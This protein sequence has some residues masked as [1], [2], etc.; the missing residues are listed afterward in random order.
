MNFEWS[1]AVQ[2]SYL[3]LFSYYMLCIC[4]RYENQISQVPT[5]L[6]LESGTSNTPVPS[7]SNEIRMS[8]SFL[9]EVDDQRFCHKVEAWQSRWVQCDS[10]AAWQ[11]GR[12]QYPPNHAI[13]SRFQLKS[14][15]GWRQPLK[16]AKTRVQCA[17][18][19][20]SMCDQR[21]RTRRCHQ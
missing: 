4:P 12:L 3:I 16:W 7:Q 8:K 6:L 17:L 9:K 19:E 20:R 5:H 13:K 11:M 21:K 2:N 15:W 14:K 18:A 1:I 10:I